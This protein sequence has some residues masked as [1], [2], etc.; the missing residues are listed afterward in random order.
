MRSQKL[1]PKSD[2]ES[3]ADHR[4][5]DPGRV[6]RQNRFRRAERGHLAPQF[7]LHA[8]TPQREQ[9]R[10]VTRA[11]IEPALGALDANKR[12]VVK[13]LAI[14]RDKRRLPA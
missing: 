4:Q 12:I 10:P 7:A 14:E 13:A 2:A 9:Q 8:Q 3:V 5:R 6:R 1:L 11:L